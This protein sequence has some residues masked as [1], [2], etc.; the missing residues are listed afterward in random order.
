MK[1]PV[2]VSF[3]CILLAF[4]APM[5]AGETAQIPVEG[6]VTMVDLGADRDQVSRCQR[7]QLAGTC[8]GEC[9]AL[10]DQRQA[11]SDAG[12]PGRCKCADSSSKA[13]MDMPGLSMARGSW[14]RSCT[15][16]W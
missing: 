15:L 16:H 3:C 14:N 7:L 2:I 4:S 11:S 9:A 10:G 12:S 1:M 13:P 6:M 5:M 8:D